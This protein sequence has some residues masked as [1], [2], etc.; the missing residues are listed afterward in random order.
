MVR[1][2]PRRPD[3]LPAGIKANVRFPMRS[4]AERGPIK[5]YPYQRG[6]ADAI[7]GLQIERAF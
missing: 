6:I 2:V 3:P 4:A 7:A 5:L 1:A